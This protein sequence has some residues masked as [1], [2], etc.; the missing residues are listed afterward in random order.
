MTNNKAT[1]KDKQ[2]LPKDIEVDVKNPR[3]DGATVPIAAEH[4]TELQRFYTAHFN[5]YLNYH[6]PCGFA[7]LE[8]SDNG[9][10]RRR[11]RLEDY[12]TPYEKLL[13]LDEWEDHLKEGI[14]AAL[15]EQQARRMSDTE[16]ALR[17][18]AIKR[19]LLAECRSRW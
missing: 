3:Y 19:K 17:M 2:K 15:L 14:S 9:K 8:V 10:R 4:A 13:S 12:R 6:R 1:S 7:T 5:P 18:Q 11:Y 16:C